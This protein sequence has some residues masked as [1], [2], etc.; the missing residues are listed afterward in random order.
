MK[1]FL[2]DELKLELSQEKTLITN[3]RT[4]AARF[5]GYEII[6]Q[7][8]DDKHC[9]K[10]R[11]VNGA[12]G[13]KAPLDVIREKCSE[14]MKN[15]KPIHRAERLNDSDFSIITQYQAEY[16]GIVQYYQKAFN[17]HRLWELHRVMKLSPAA[18]PTGRCVLRGRG[19]GNTLLLPDPFI[20][21]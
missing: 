18:Y 6:N 21:S 5:L 7:D 3:A 19:S 20:N 17:V 10:Q 2:L 8:A 14:Y 12:S 9:R 11:N 15:S 1:E 16:R 13:L 4:E